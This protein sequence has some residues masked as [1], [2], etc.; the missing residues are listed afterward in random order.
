[1]QDARPT[2]PQ[3]SATFSRFGVA[4]DHALASRVGASM[5]REGGNA[6]DAAVATSFAL[7]VVRPY[8]CGIGGGGFL[9]AHSHD[10]LK[11]EG[12]QC[13]TVLD[14]RET[15]PA[16]INPTFFEQGSAAED[17]FA[18]ERGGLAVAVPGHVRGMLRALSRW[19]TREP[20]DVLAGAIQLA[21][22][23]FKAD[24]HYVESCQEI[25]EWIE[26]RDK[27]TE[28][29][30]GVACERDGNSAPSAAQLR[31]QRMQRFAWLWKR[32]LREGKIRVGDRLHFPEQAALLR[33]IGEQGDKAFYEG[34]CA[35]AIVR[36]VS[37]DKGVLSLQ[38]LSSY[39]PKLREPFVTS[40]LGKRVLSMPP[41]SSGGIVLAQVFAM[42]EELAPRLRELASKAEN[43]NSAEFIH[44]V[45][46]CCKHAFA[47]RAHY[48]GDSDFVALELAQLLDPLALR[49]RARTIEIERTRQQHEYGSAI[50]PP[51]LRG[52]GT[53]HLCVVDAKGNAVA[54]TET[55][56]LVFG[57]LL[58]VPE[59]GFVLNDTMD[60]F[61]TRGGQANAF[62]L[63][64]AE[65]NR[66]QPGKRPLSAMTPTIVLD[67]DR[68]DARAMLLAGASGGPRIISGTLQAILN[69]LVWKMPAWDAVEKPRFH[70]QWSPHVL[71][72]EDRLFGTALQ[73]ELEKKG[74]EV[75]K[76]QPVAAVQVMQLTRSKG[77]HGECDA[78]IDGDCAWQAASDPRKGGAPVG[79]LM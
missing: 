58:A 69:M 11:G 19:G 59:F 32:L 3:F 49:E 42:L 72:L 57:S 48:L 34:A 12:G 56:N 74:H 70:H 25:I 71:Q 43:H 51:A 45:G 9:L 63:A 2:T 18:S 10:G 77:Q 38:D 44:L 54:C 23:G 30:L 40:F 16:A 4:A 33:A 15:C 75:G 35:E 79:E 8:S 31:E 52:G 21:H 37:S 55:I 46:E 50:A 53:S 28:A 64:H 29:L 60:D 17:R 20:S 66:P 14:Y 47:D 1:M 13:T 76:R 62:G 78:G 73:A 7:S 6:V 41:P 36:A 5:L 68:S 61:L 26:A 39:E 27:A 67:A 65:R 24:P 22:E